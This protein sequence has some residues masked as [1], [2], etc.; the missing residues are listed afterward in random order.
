MRSI[1]QVTSELTKESAGPRYLGL[2]EMDTAYLLWLKSHP[3][4][5]VLLFSTLFHSL[6]QV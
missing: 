2:E 3:Q 6:T 5:L 1:A 4:T